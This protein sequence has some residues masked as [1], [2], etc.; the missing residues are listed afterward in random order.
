MPGHLSPFNRGLMN[1]GLCACLAA[2][3]F[4]LGARAATNYS[5]ARLQQC[6]ALNIDDDG[7][8]VAE[9]DQ[10]CYAAFLKELGR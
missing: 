9:P 8:P 5:A 2:F 10:S 7:A 3:F 6:Y 4:V 1:G